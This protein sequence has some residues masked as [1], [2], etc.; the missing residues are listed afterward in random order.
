MIQI[1]RKLN[2]GFKINLHIMYWFYNYIVI[3]YIIHIAL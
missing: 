3:I 2:L 1:I